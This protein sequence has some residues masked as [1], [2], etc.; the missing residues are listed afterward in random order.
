MDK[1]EGRTVEIVYLAP[2]GQLSQ[3]LIRI[4]GVKGGFVQALC[5]KTGQPRTFRTDRILAAI[6]V[7]GRAG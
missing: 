3:R 1:Y 6:P 2:D 4:R 7:A 5:L